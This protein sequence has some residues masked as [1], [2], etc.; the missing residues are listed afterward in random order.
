MKRLSF[1]FSSAV[2]V[3]AL[4]L[5]GCG[6]SDSSGGAVNTE[7]VESSFSG[8]DASL[9]GSVDAIVAAVKAQNWS[10]AS[11]EIQK[12]ASNAKLTPEQKAAIDNLWEQVKARVS[13]AAAQ[14]GDVANKAMKDAGAAL[15]KAVKDAGKSLN[16]LGGQPKK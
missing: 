14:A 4:L 15:D 2:L 12:L 8:A 3:A 5:S 6:G 11:A 13:A 10:A 16:D 9:K 1:F 7:K